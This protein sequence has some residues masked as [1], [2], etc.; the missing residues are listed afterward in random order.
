LTWWRLTDEHRSDSKRH[1]LLVYVG[2]VESVKHTVQ[3]GDG[4]VLVG[5]DRKVELGSVGER[6]DILDP[7]SVRVDVVGGKTDQLGVSGVRLTSSILLADEAVR[8]LDMG[9]WMYTATGPI[10]VM[11]VARA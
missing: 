3:L 1:S 10:W 5:D 7:S 8:G 11:K 2:L 9:I 4:T 6:V